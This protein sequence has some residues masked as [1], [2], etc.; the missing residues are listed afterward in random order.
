MNKEDTWKNNNFFL[1]TSENVDCVTSSYLYGYCITE[2]NIYRNQAIFDRG[3]VNAI[4]AVG[5]WILIEKKEDQI[6]MTQDLNGCYLIYYYINEDYWAV[7][8]DFWLICEEVSKKYPLTL[9]EQ[10]AMHYIN[11]PMSAVTTVHTLLNEI[12][13]VPLFTNILIKDGQMTLQEDV[14]IMKLGTVSLDSEAGMEIIDQWIM[15][16]GGI[17]QS[18]YQAG[19]PIQFDLSGGFDSRVSFALGVDAGIEFNQ[20]HIMV[21]SYIAQNAGAA[22]HYSDDY[23]I[24]KKIADKIGF[25]LNKEIK[26]RDAVRLSAQDSYDVY[27]HAFSGVH[28]EPYFH[29]SRNRNPKFIVKGLFGETVR[30]NLRSLNHN[31]KSVRKNK[32]FDSFTFLELIESYESACEGLDKEDK[33]Y[34]HKTL[35]KYKMQTQGRTHEGLVSVENAFVNE[36]TLDPLSDINL[37]KV[38]P[39]IENSNVDTNIIFAVILFRCCPGLAEIPFTNGKRFSEETLKKAKYLHTT[40]P[41]KSRVTMPYLNL[42]YTVLKTAGLFEEVKKGEDTNAKSVLLDFF[43]NQE[44]QKLFENK[45]G[46]YG[47][48]LRKEAEKAYMEN[49]KYMPLKDIVRIVSVSRALY[50]EHVSSPYNN[51]LVAYHLEI[52]RMKKIAAMYPDIDIYAKYL[53]EL[54]EIR[55][56]EYKKKTGGDKNDVS[57]CKS[58]L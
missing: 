14:S 20:E 39:V 21:K 34:E 10:F 22:S 18:A 25:E 44:Y 27:D 50:Y 11:T 37:L 12:R 19:I 54:E 4:D 51:D 6:V 28:P 41:R 45:Y 13:I 36:Y 57:N 38:N 9:N 16:W 46:K 24:A 32:K 17:I 29:P 23:T 30:M 3:G 35:Q 26:G 53:D 56:L 52:K 5:A 2:N 33:N 55:N 42:D 1:I 7:S 8:N 47:I 15:K 58:V 40:Y 48:L 49:K 43:Y 31:S